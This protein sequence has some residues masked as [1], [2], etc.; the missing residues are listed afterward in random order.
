MRGA[1]A[2]FAADKEFDAGATIVSAVAMGR[3]SNGGDN[4][5]AQGMSQRRGGV[6]CVSEILRRICFSGGRG[7][8]P[9]VRVRMFRGFSH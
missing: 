4:I 3:P 5:A 9:D 2:E 6:V 8:S 1:R 7:L